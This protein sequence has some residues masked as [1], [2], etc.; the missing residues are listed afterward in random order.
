MW[1]IPVGVKIGINP[2]VSKYAQ[3]IVQILASIPATAIFPI[4]LLFLFKF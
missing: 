1:T 3:P 2:K 4:I